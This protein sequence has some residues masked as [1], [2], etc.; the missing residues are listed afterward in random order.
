MNTLTTKEK[1]TI[2]VPQLVF[3]NTEKK[4]IGGSEGG[5]GRGEVERAGESCAGVL[6]RL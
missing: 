5:G 4:R 1:G 3:A 2:W 6:N